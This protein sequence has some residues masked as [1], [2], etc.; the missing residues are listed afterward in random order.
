MPS[1]D[2]DVSAVN[3]IVARFVAE[4]AKMELPVYAITADSDQVTLGQSVQL[5]ISTRDTPFTEEPIMIN[6]QISTQSIGFDFD[7][8]IPATSQ[9]IPA[10]TGAWSFANGASSYVIQLD[11]I[12][13]TRGGHVII[14]Y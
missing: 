1:G 10:N 6:Y 2:Y 4:S 11:T 3:R 14:R 5:T 13:S 7:F 9:V 12:A 8:S